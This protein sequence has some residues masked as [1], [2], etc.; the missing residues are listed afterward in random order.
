MSLQGV[1][2]NSACSK[3]VAVLWDR[4]LKRARHIGSFLTEEEAAKAYD[5][6]AL[7]MLGPTHAGLNFRE[8]EFGMELCFGGEPGI[9]MRVG[10]GEWRR[11]VSR[12]NGKVKRRNIRASITM[13]EAKGWTHKIRLKADRKV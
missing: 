4:Q 13:A 2:W 3:W 5:R 6:K 12:K 11:I 9:F 7:E 1:S 8:S 10:V